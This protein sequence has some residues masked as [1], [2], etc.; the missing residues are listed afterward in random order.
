MKRKKSL[1]CVLEYNTNLFKRSRIERMAGHF[2]ELAKS[3]MIEPDQKIKKIQLLTDPEKKLILREWNATTVDFPKE[4]CIYQLFEE[5]VART[6]NAIAISDDRRK[7]TYTTLN[8]KSNRLAHHLNHSGAVEGSL[9]A[10]CIER[11]TDLLVALLAIQKAGCTYI[12]LDPIYPKD[13]IALILEDGNPVVLLTEKR[14]CWKICQVTAAKTYIYRRVGC[15]SE[16][17]RSEH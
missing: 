9:V 5:Q 6:P 7:V 1:N 4:K 10:I 11:S 14:N 8:E 16:R 13:R 2:L 12:P 3:L 15:L 17:I